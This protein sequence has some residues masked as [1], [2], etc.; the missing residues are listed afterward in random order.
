MGFY[1][2]IVDIFCG[3][4][5][6]AFYDKWIDDNPEEVIKIVETLKYTVATDKEIMRD[7]E[8]NNK[9]QS[10]Q[11]VTED[12]KQREEKLIMDL[13]SRA[14][15]G[16][17]LAQYEL[18]RI[19]ENGNTIIPKDKATAMKLYEKSAAQGY[20]PA[21]EAVKHV[22]PEEKHEK[23]KLLSPISN[24]SEKKKDNRK[25]SI[26]NDK[27]ESGFFEKLFGDTPDNLIK[28]AQEDAMLMS[29]SPE[30]KYKL[31]CLHEN[32]GGVRVQKDFKAAVKLY[33]EA[34]EQGYQPAIDALRR[35]APEK[36]MKSKCSEEN[37]ISGKKMAGYL[38]DMAN[39]G[40]ESTKESEKTT[41]LQSVE[42][43]EIPKASEKGGK[44][45]Q[46]KNEERIKAL[47]KLSYRELKA[48]AE[49]DGEA[50]NILGEK[51]FRG[52]GVPRDLKKAVEYL[53]KAVEQNNTQAMMSLAYL[54]NE[55]FGVEQNCTRGEA[56][57]L[58]ADFLGEA[59]APGFLAETYIYGRGHVER[60]FR[61]GFKYAKKAL[62]LGDEGVLLM[63]GGNREMF[64][65]LVKYIES[66]DETDPIFKQLELMIEKDSAKKK[67]ENDHYISDDPFVK[68]ILNSIK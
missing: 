6:K 41:A 27:K 40:F 5:R 29:N 8:S 19:Y 37:V 15:K 10:Y 3:K 50:Q 52:D 60:D 56:L 13:G 58:K 42:S 39:S 61:K 45:M 14:N 20:Q 62:E 32:G 26:S 65:E 31:A 17:A 30:S 9:E 46:V 64:E 51:F 68:N 34:A 33:E 25:V 12:L 36:L 2:T 59:E 23:T 24:E 63:L 7:E 11:L 35:I 57:V 4:K 18:G 38:V 21:I 48:L 43:R 44:K 47:R 1:N 53:G 54:F 66:A 28:A 67:Y 55:G 22:V 49:T 16:D